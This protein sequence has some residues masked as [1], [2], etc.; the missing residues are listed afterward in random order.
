MPTETKNSTA[1]ASRS[2]S[3]SCAARWLSV[4]SLRIMPA[5]NAPSANDTSNSVGGAVGDAERDRQHREAEQLA[6]A[7]MRDVMQQPR[8]DAAPDQPHQRDEGREL[9]ER[10]GERQRRRLEKSTL[11]SPCVESR[12]SAGRS[13]RTSTIAR[14]STTSQ[15]TAMRPRSVSSSRRSCSARSTTTVLATE[16]ARPNTSPP[17]SGQPSS[18]PSPTPSAVATTICAIAPGHRDGAHRQ[19]ILERELQPDAEHQ[20]D[21]ADLGELVGDALVGDEAR[22][23]RPDHDAGEQIADER[24]GLQPMRDRAEREGQHEADHDGRRQGRVQL[25]RGSSG[26]RA[27]QVIH[28]R[29]ADV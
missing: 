18:S 4:D 3:V 28:A 24:R 9:A 15:P 12:A 19:Q 21:D 27:A 2:G 5:K 13:T 16:S 10:D 20:Q 25:H 22:R 6:R 26:Q 17:P 23:E 29:A 8:D 11:R 14:S 7:G 1:K